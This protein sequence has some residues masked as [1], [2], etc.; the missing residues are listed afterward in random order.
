MLHSQLVKLHIPAA[1]LYFI[2]PSSAGKKPKTHTRLC[3]C[4]CCTLFGSVGAQ[5]IAPCGH[6]KVG[7]A[8]G[9]WEPLTWPPGSKRSRRRCSERGNTAAI[10]LTLAEP[11]KTLRPRRPPVLACGYRQGSKW[12]YRCCV[13]LLRLWIRHSLPQVEKKNTYNIQWALRAER[14]ERVMGSVWKYLKPTTKIF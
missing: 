6:M 7:M 4:S 13:A 10:M 5:P 12:T 9:G 11:G 14:W 8:A 2:H 1:S 3:V